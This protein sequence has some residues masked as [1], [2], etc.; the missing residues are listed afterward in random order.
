MRHGAKLKGTEDAGGHVDGFV[1]AA[2]PGR[3]VVTVP[4]TRYRAKQFNPAFLRGK[5][6]PMPD[7]L[8]RAFA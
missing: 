7:W 4:G 8:A 2:G 6:I 1:C 5:G 3:T